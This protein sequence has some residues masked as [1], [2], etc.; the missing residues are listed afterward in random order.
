[1]P[2]LVSWPS[3]SSIK[4]GATSLLV[5]GLIER[6][7][8]LNILRQSGKIS[9][10]EYVLLVES[11]TQ[12]LGKENSSV[13]SESWEPP[14][15]SA[16]AA[17]RK[18]AAEFELV[19]APKAMKFLE[20]IKFS[21]NNYLNFNGRASRSEFWYWVLFNILAVFGLSFVATVLG[22]DQSSLDFFVGIFILSSIIPNLARIVRRL[23]DTNK[24]WQFALFALVPLVGNVLLTVWFCTKS[25]IGGNRF[26][27]SKHGNDESSNSGATRPNTYEPLLD[28]HETKSQSSNSSLKNVTQTKTVL[29]VATVLAIVGLALQANVQYGKLISTIEIS[30]SQMEEFSERVLELSRSHVSSTGRFLSEENR[31]KWEDGK[32]YWA[33]V[34][35]SRIRN[36]GDAIES[37]FL[38]PWNFSHQVVKSSYM[39]HNFAWQ[40]GLASEKINPYSETY[41]DE[42]S[43]T[44]TNF[45]SELK[46][47]VP[48]YSFGRFDSRIAKICISDADPVSD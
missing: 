27:P 18:P 17:S 44:W 38:M 36:A 20:T 3:R 12:K 48:W 16:N 45:C 19:N 31:I 7:N 39:S 8:E 35:E 34:F 46:G 15:D 9:D 1:V 25:D 28:K 47:R 22:F 42:I 26:G 29:V 37:V 21:Y 40:K 13:K 2:Y 23:H 33:D 14:Y 43:S 41:S 4:L 32:K 5:M 24:P 6:L 10:S 11:A 30:E